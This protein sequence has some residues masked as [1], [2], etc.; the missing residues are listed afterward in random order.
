MENSWMGCMWGGGGGGDFETWLE[1][2]SH[3]LSDPLPYHYCCIVHVPL[4]FFALHVFYCSFS[5]S[6]K[7]KNSPTLSEFKRIL[8]K[9]S[10]AAFIL[11]K[12]I[13]CLVMI[14]DEL[15]PVIVS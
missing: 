7:H 6:D 15:F 2:P 4:P 13:M 10:Y 1:R 9:Y 11:I 5:F 14:V 12:Q 8:P 3:F